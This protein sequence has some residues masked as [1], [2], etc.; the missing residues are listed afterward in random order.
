M[1]N[2]NVEWTLPIGPLAVK[3]AKPRKKGD[4][5][6]TIVHTMSKNKMVR[7]LS[8][9]LANITKVC[10]G[11]E[12]QFSRK[13]EPL[14]IV[15]HPEHVNVLRMRF[16]INNPGSVTKLARLPGF[17]WLRAQSDYSK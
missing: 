6:R 17:A 8:E 3:K 1:Q 10:Q 9:A 2:P 12:P 13:Y 15:K 16:Y 14:K 4:K 7:H 11:R 5:P